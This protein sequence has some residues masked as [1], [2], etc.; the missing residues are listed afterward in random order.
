M[1]LAIGTR[2][3]P[4]RVV[5]PFGAGGMGEVFG[6][7]DLRLAPDGAIKVLSQRQPPTAEIRAAAVEDL[8]IHKANVHSQ[9]GEDGV[10]EAVFDRLGIGPGRCCEFGAWDGIHLSNCRKLILEGWH[11]VMIEGEPHRFQDL[12]RTYRGNPQVTCVN[13][14]VDTG[15]NSVD[16]IHRE[17]GL[18]PPDF[19]SI[20]IDGLDY[21]IFDSLVMRP[22]VI[23]IEVA[24]VHDPEAPRRIQ[25]E[26]AARGVGQPLPVF[27]EIAARKGYD[28]VAYTSNAFFVRSDL[29]AKAALPVLTAAAA[30]SNYLAHLETESREFLLLSNLGLRPPFFRFNNSCLGA[31]AL[32]VSPLRALRLVVS[33]VLVPLQLRRVAGRAFRAVG[34]RRGQ[35]A[36]NTRTC[37]RD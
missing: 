37:P 33:A 5:A 29:R 32:G 27:M 10:I 24:G 9:F 13:R 20:D 17:L 22:A 34:L 26:I 11:A 25:R 1:P 35:P 15:T 36:G 30:Y 19:L 3:G 7:Q 6:A 31:R 18:E 14:F 23:C 16:S 28:L 4:F 21:E 8:L 2:L 12:L